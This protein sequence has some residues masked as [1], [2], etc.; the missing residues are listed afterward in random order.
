MW[1]RHYER[2]DGQVR[3]RENS[4]LGRV[5]DA[6]ESPYDPQARFS[7]KRSLVWTGYK[8]HLT[9]T[10]DEDTPNLIIHVHTTDEQKAVCPGGKTSIAWRAHR[11]SGK[12][13][14]DMYVADSLRRT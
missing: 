3:W 4:E 12:Y 6:V 7:T 8:V 1:E 11:T 13:A 2:K 10:C 14:Q 9:E 5:T